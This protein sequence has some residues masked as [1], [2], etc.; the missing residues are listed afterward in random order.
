MKILLLSNKSPWPPKDGGSAATLASIRGLSACGASVSVIALNTLK[1]YIEPENITAECTSYCD[2]RLI[3]AD[4]RIKPHKLLG[5]LWFSQRPYTLERFKSNELNKVLANTDL[6]SFDIIQVE[7]LAM[8]SFI[9]LL[10]KLTRSII[11]FRPHNIENRIW[12][13][14]SENENDLVRRYYFGILASRTAPI[15]RNIINSVD[16]IAAM[17]E[18]DL[19]WF[20]AS[21]VSRP[22]IVCHSGF[23]MLKPELKEGEKNQIFF[24]GSL[25]WLP[26]INGLKWFVKNV[27]PIVSGSVPE[28]VLHIAGRNP[29]SRLGRICRGPKIIFHGEVGSSSG[30]M[31]DK[32]VMVVPLFEGSGLRMKIIEGMSMG[33][34][35]VAT[36][37]AAEGIE[38]SDGKDIFISSDENSFAGCIMR[39]LGDPGLR[40]NTAL[41]AMENVRKNYDIFASAEKLMKFYRELI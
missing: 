39:L 3:D 4:T 18:I 37:A 30:F 13:Q 6:K 23:P 9:P 33:K 17:T 19:K 32:Q 41:N 27:W 34:S 36:P 29:S 10:R 25:D 14:L 20:K 28:A 22:S 24:I 26:N 5:N 40:K 12:K 15:E 1:H 35:I 21:G 8:T 16:G 38:Y 7:G 31:L 11:I 2:I